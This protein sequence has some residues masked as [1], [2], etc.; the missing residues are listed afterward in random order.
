MVGSSGLRFGVLL[1]AAAVCAVVALPAA[2]SEPAAHGEE[3]VASYRLPPEAIARYAARAAGTSADESA[4]L[5]SMLADRSPW[6]GPE[7]RAGVGRNPYTLVLTVSGVARAAGDVHAQWQA[8]WELIE[9]PVAS[10]ELLMSLSG[11]A[12]KGVAAGQALTMTT[13]SAPVSFRGDRQVAPM[14]GLVQTRNLD[15]R[16]VQVEVWSGSAPLPWPALP[17]VPLASAGAATIGALALLA[18]WQRA[19]LRQH[20]HGADARADDEDED[21]G[22]GL[23]SEAPPPPFR[24]TASHDL[25]VFESLHDVLRHGLVVASVPDETRPP[26]RARTPRPDA[27]TA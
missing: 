3:L 12:R 17:W 13:R 25:R 2:R 27:P 14:L 7:H 9:S 10:R 19:R 21:S 6:V 11:L 16:D 1:A 5:T 24:A 20:R 8:G 22:H 4:R 23:S 26:R 15:I 18:L